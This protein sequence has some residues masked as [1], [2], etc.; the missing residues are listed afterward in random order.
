MGCTRRNLKKKQRRR[1]KKNIILPVQLFYACYMA[2][3]RIISFL[4][5]KFIHKITLSKK[6]RPVHA[7][8]NKIPLHHCSGGQ[9][10]WTL[11]ATF[12][13]GDF[14]ARTVFEGRVEEHV[15]SH[16]NRLQGS[17]RAKSITAVYTSM[18]SS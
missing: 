8:I 17:A 6:C 4:F 2:F 10:H 7:V 18:Q 16:V 5:P 3:E 9:Y 15:L 11:K 1:I 13:L 14:L 12:R